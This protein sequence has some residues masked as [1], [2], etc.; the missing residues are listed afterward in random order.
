MGRTMTNDK[1]SIRSAFD[2]INL[3]LLALEATQR[4]TMK[5]AAMICLDDAGRSWVRGDY[6]RATERASDSLDFSVGGTIEIALGELRGNYMA[7]R[8]RA[9]FSAARGRDPVF[10]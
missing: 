7:A 6:Q 4:E 2:A 8:R 10:K 3:G 1:P 9:A 5:A